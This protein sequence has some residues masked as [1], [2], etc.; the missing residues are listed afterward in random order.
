MRTSLRGSWAKAVKEKLVP[1]PTLPEDY[2]WLWA[3]H[4]LARHVQL[5]LW[6]NNPLQ[7]EFEFASVES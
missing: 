5:N 2:R 1:L 7:L 6:D 4:L 3:D